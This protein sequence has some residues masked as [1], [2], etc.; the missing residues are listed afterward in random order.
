MK[1]VP[2]KI[3]NFVMAGFKSVKAGDSGVVGVFL[4]RKTRLV[5]AGGVA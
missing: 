3:K 1:L 5:L 2:E 4:G